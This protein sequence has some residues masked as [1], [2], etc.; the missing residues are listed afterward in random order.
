MGALKLTFL[1][2]AALCLTTLVS[3]TTTSGSFCSISHPI[4]LSKK[5]VDA[6][7]DAEVKE[8][9]THNRTGQKLCGW[10]Q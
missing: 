5:T 7:T 1:S 4:R 9:L 2:L 3:C 10:R 8:I 6:L